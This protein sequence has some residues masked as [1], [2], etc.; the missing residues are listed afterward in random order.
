MRVLLTIF[1]ILITCLFFTSCN[2]DEKQLPFPELNQ[3]IPEGTT[4]TTQSIF[5]NIL[6]QSIHY[7]VFLPYGYDTSKI[8]YP[9]LYL[10]HGMGGNHQDWIKHD[11]ARTLNQSISDKSCKSMVVIMP[12]R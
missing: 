7:S 9:V 12:E 5:S 11:M 10:L 8:L 3:S 6:K 1:I 2:K 4:D